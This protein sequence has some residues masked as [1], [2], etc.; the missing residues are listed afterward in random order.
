[1][2]DD[3]DAAGQEQ[4]EVRMLVPPDW[5]E[6]DLDPDHIDQTVA[7]LLGDEP[8]DPARQN[9][10]RRRELRQF[11]LQARAAILRAHQEGGIAMLHFWATIDEEPHF[12]AASVVVYLHQLSGS[13]ESMMGEL[14]TSKKEVEVVDL[15]DGSFCVRVSEVSHTVIEGLDDAVATLGVRYYRPIEDSPFTATLAFTTP[16][17]PLADDF[18]ALFDDMVS[19]FRMTLPDAMRNPEP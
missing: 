7:S 12:M 19:T 3:V 8:D 18:T 16:N 1:M 14:D 10:A 5:A 4:P 15:D 2:N 9:D 11:E 6:V 17:V 13:L